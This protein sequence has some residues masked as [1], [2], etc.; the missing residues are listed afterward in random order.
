MPP[1]S[2]LVTGGAGYIGSHTVAR[3]VEAGRDVVVVDTLELGHAGALA[4]VPFVR[5]DVADRAA[6]ASVIEEH[7]VD[8]VVH[9]AAYKAVGESMR[10]P[11]RYFANNVG[12]TNALLDTL[13]LAGVDRFVFSSTCAVYGTVDRLPI[14]ET[15]P[16]HPESVY[17]ETKALVERILGWYDICHRLRSV[18]LRYFN[19]A[20]ASLD[21]SIG[22]DWSMSENLIPLVMKTL[23]GRQKRLEV[24]GTDYPTPD[25]TNIRDYVH[26]VDLADAHLRA[27]EYLEKGG[28]TTAVNLGTGTGSSVFEVIEAARRASG[29]DIEPE[30]VGRR[31]GDPVALYADA[32]L[33]K[34]L[35]GW[36]ARYDL[37]DIV[38]SAWRW[39]S[40]HPDGYGD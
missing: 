1:V 6:I 22:E 7:D 10:D 25:G 33:A 35:L 11:G 5:A 37:D 29:K 26:V 27:L 31:A 30:L 8:A 17:G 23:L 14:D 28:A 21:G 24:Y 16:V 36:V 3:L 12:G 9:F 39:H 38:A 18:S 4:G 20:G 15:L 13:R 34:E 32:G 40:T 19:A 2:I